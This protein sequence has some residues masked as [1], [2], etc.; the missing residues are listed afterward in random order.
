MAQPLSDL[1]HVQEFFSTSPTKKR[2]I[3][4]MFFHRSFAFIAD[5]L[6]DLINGS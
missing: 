1:A 5:A 2:L 4:F 3:F 6:A